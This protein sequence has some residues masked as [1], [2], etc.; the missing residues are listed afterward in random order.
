MFAEISKEIVEVTG[1]RNGKHATHQL[2]ERHPVSSLGGSG[3]QRFDVH[4]PDH[5]VQVA[6]ENRKA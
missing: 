3:K 1:F 6:V 5:M 2:T 4:H